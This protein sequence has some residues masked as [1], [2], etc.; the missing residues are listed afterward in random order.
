[1]RNT[2][3]QGLGEEAEEQLLFNRQI[4][5]VWNDEEALETGGC[6]GCTTCEFT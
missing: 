2:G 3:W 1:M 6:D 4:I 5:S